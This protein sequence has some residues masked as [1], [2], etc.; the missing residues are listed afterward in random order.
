MSSR[1]PLLLSPS[2]AKAV[3]GLGE[4]QATHPSSSKLVAALRLEKQGQE[5]LVRS[6]GICKCSAKNSTVCKAFT[7]PGTHMS[8]TKRLG[9]GDGQGGQTVPNTQRRI[10]RPREEVMGQ[11]PPGPHRQGGNERPEPLAWSSGHIFL[12]RPG[13]A[14]A[15]M[16]GIF[17]PARLNVSFMCLSQLILF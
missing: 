14:S 1:S 15:P 11:R 10:R 6:K 8:V 4:G 17:R 16:S 13:F 2:P 3:L 7:L 12:V 5:A 9:E